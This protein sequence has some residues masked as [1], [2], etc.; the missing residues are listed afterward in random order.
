V[1]KQIYD[2]S[3]PRGSLAVIVPVYNGINAFK[4]LINSLKKQYP[5][6]V[7]WLKFCFIDDASTNI[8]IPEYLSSEQFFKRPDVDVLHNEKNIGF[9]KTV[10][11]GI[12]HSNRGHDVLILNSDTI[13]PGPVF[14]SLRAAANRIGKFGS[15]TPLTNRGTIASILNWP[16]GSDS[17]FDLTP[18][19]VEVSIRNLG[20]RVDHIEIPTGVGFCMLMSRCAIDEVGILDENH[21]GKGYGEEND[22]CQRAKKNGFLNFLCFETFV[23]HQDTQSFSKKEKD[24]LIKNNLKT[25]NRIHK[26][27][28]RDV[29]RFIF[30]DR[31]QVYRFQI[32]WLLSRRV[33]H[34]NKKFTIFYAL[35]K[36]PWCFY[37]GT[38]RHVLD[39]ARYGLL[40]NDSEILLL[41][42]VAE[43]GN[44]YWRLSLVLTG[45]LK[46]ATSI[47]LTKQEVLEVLPVLVK[48]V[49][50]LHAHHLMGWPK[51]I[52]SKMLDECIGKKLITLHDYIAI[53]P[54][55]NMLT[56]NGTRFCEVEQDE[57]KC[58][59]C[60]HKYHNGEMDSIVDYTEKWIDVLDRFDKI[61]FPSTA[62]ENIFKRGISRWGIGKKLLSQLEVFENPLCFAQKASTINESETSK[63]RVVFLGGFSVPKGSELVKTVIPKLKRAGFHVEI[64]GYFNGR[65]KCKVRKYETH[66]ELLDIARKYPPS[67]V[68]LPFI[69]PETFSFTTFEALALLGVP[70]VVGQYGN[71]AEYVSKYQCG[72]VMQ[73]D[74]VMN[75]YQSVL[76][77]NNEY[78][79]YLN[80]A[81]IVRD[82]ILDKYTEAYN[83][84]KVIELY[85]LESCKKSEIEFDSQNDRLQIHYITDRPNV[86]N[87]SFSSYNL[88]QYYFDLLNAPGIWGIIKRF[89]ILNAYERPVLKQLMQKVFMLIKYNKI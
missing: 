59:G 58:S 15:I 84:E 76:N 35:H 33:K 48:H 83:C 16:Y 66:A 85:E 87:I 71:P 6:N 51:E 21:F 67:I 23:Y 63:K 45:S 11:K 65:I 75:L 44:Q 69:W 56:D 64:W 4:R 38:E 34:K 7:S 25:L 55:P 50:V 12:R 89:I 81:R 14:E 61:L 88:R 29:A 31:F 52:I 73:D 19:Q 62:A 74:T 2:D 78:E 86:E 41:N 70:V 49:D 57:K 79:R 20:L 8:N 37:G 53:C 36:D 40:N 82:K 42:P 22:W 28:S 54:S 68:A 1:N 30:E 80:S 47:L 9:V 39:L 46:P 13:I 60:Y 24:N 27:Y 18:E 10:N 72:I 77:I 43:T 26:H 5:N 3:D 17:V 32:I